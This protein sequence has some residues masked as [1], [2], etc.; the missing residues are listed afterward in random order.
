MKQ[1]KK[2]SFI[3]VVLIASITIGGVCFGLGYFTAHRKVKDLSEYQTFYATITEMK[4][5]VISVKG[6]DV[7]DI[8]YRS[9]FVLS[10]D[11]NTRLTWRYTDI[12]AKDIK[13]GDHI[14][15]TFSG[16]IQETY[17]AKITQVDLIQ[18]LEDE[19]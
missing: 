1:N 12:D 10:I 7:N 11:K 19:R 14:S 3:L 16:W 6:L 2:W 8:N 17:P 5:D 4:D 9:D 15:I 13:V 18:L